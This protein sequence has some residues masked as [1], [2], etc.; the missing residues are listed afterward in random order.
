MRLPPIALPVAAILALSACS[1]PPAEPEAVATETAAAAVPATT[2]SA[3]PSAAPSAPPEASASAT[4]TLTP[5]A[6]PSAKPVAAAAG[7]A[8]PSPVAMTAALTPPASFARCAVC[9]DA[10]K[11]GEDK[12]GPNLWGVYG[13]TAGQGSFAFS[14]ELK[15]ANLVLNDANLDKWLENPRALVPGNRMSFPGL[16]DPA[17]R[18]EIIAFL[19]AAR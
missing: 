10:K 11:G 9:H 13:K 15:A 4:P 18:Q 3:A 17:K 14:D 19:K 16:K 6:T 8:S 1:G 7:I 5:S 2:A 12:L